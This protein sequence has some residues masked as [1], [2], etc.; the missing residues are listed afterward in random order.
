MPSS[1]SSLASFLNMTISI[2]LDLASFLWKWLQCDFNSPQ[3]SV[4]LLTKGAIF[5]Q[6][7]AQLSW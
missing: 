2:P 7:K 1:F 6:Q 4:L 3:T 5:A